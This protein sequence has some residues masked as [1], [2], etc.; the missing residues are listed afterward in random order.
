MN[1]Q[2]N[3]VCTSLS[4]K[5]VGISLSVLPEK[6]FYFIPMSFGMIFFCLYNKQVLVFQLKKK[7]IKPRLSKDCA[8]VKNL[9]SHRNR[10]N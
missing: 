10:S 1:T 2:K 6:D 7:E 4:L 9:V 3:C 8:G 5:K